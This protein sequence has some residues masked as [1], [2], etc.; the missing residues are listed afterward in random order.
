MAKFGIQFAI[1]GGM[2]GPATRFG[3]A[4]S[5]QEPDVTYGDL[6]RW[7]NTAEERG[8]D[9][10]ELPETATNEAHTASVA[11][12]MDT[13]RVKIGTAVSPIY[14]RG[15]VLMASQI[16]SLHV[17][18]GGRAMLGLGWGHEG[19]LQQ[20]GI[21]SDL[22]I[23]RMREYIE[24]IRLLL[25]GGRVVYK[26]QY[27]EVRGASLLPEGSGVNIPVYI[28]AAGT[29]ALQLAGEIADGVYLPTLE[30][31]K[32]VEHALKQ[33]QIGAERAGR[34]IGDID[35]ISTAEISVTDDVEAAKRRLKELK[36]FHFIARVSDNQVRIEGLGKEQQL[37]REAIKEGDLDKAVSFVTDSIL[38][39]FCVYGSLSECRQKMERFASLGITHYRLHPNGR[40]QREA[41]EGGLQLLSASKEVRQ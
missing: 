39:K 10:V 21:D 5:I 31:Y 26:G 17:I 34:K 16:L 15:P 4:D 30:S 14:L 12:A 6:I 18:S 40:T 19:S 28:G 24:I 38:E 37:V 22:S 13:R 32:Y 2:G 23:Q 3:K 8:F 7:A 29:K 41:I 1:G 35:V 11:M 20:A 25:N 36:V 33:I 27:Y 9:F